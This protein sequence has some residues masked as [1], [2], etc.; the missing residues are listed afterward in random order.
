ML[1]TAILI[2]PLGLTLMFMHLKWNHFWH[3]VHSII[4][5]G[6]PQ[7]QYSSMMICLGSHLLIATEFWDG[8]KGLNVLASKQCWMC[9][10]ILHC[11][12]LFAC[13]IVCICNAENTTVH[14]S[15]LLLYRLYVNFEF[16]V[17]CKFMPYIWAIAV[18][19]DLR[20]ILQ[21]NSCRIASV[22]H[23]WSWK[24]PSALFPPTNS[25]W[26]AACIII[27]IGDNYIIQLY[28]PAACPQ[29]ARN[30]SLFCGGHAFPFC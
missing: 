7:V 4:V 15:F 28:R 5:S 29:I 17:H 9:E 24:Q 22:F 25:I 1:C 26:M 18:L 2:P 11:F 30:T 10:R 13:S 3:S 20:L 21:L 6:R 19:E 14:F 12:V 8:G 27:I 23:W 16:V